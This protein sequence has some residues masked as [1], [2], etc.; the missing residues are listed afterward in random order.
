MYDDVTLCK[1]FFW[2]GVCYVSHKA[3]SENIDTVKPLYTDFS[4]FATCNNPAI[5]VINAINVCSG[6]DLDSSQHGVSSEC[7]ALGD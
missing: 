6:E 3:M 2:F 5:N 1:D 4:Q 7:F